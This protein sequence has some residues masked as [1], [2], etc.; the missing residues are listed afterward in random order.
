MRNQCK[1]CKF[2]QEDGKC[3]ATVDAYQIKVIA[4]DK[5]CVFKTTQHD[6]VM[7]AYKAGVRHKQVFTRE[8]L[9][10]INKEYISLKEITEEV[11]KYMDKGSE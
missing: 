6:F 9:A 4:G 2:L 10:D 11:K 5:R 7:N 3:G 8:Y 1:G